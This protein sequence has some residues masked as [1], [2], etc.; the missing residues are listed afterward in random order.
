MLEARIWTK[1]LTLEEIVATANHSLTGYERELLAY[2]RMDEGKGETITDYAHGATLYL[3]GCS[4]NKQKGFSLRLDGTNRAQLDGNLLGRSTTY[5]ETILFW[6]KAESEGTLFCADSTVL[7]IE[8]GNVVF[9][10]GDQKFEITNHKCT[11]GAWH[12]LVLTIS[13]TY[14]NAALFLD[15]NLYLSFDALSLQAITGAMYLGGDGFT[16]NIDEFVIFEQALPKPLVEVYEDIALT[17]DEMGLMA[18]LPFEEQ[19][20]NPSGVLQLRFSGNDKRVYKNPETGEVIDKI[21]PLIISDVTGMEDGDNNAPVKSHG[22]LNKLNFNWSFNNNELMINILN[23]DYEVNKQSIYVSVRDVEDLNGNPMASPVT[24]T[25]FVDRNSLKWSSKQLIIKAD[26]TTDDKPEAE[27]RIVNQSGKRHT[28]NIE[29]LPSWLSVDE[30]YG[31]IDP[32][33]EIIVTL[34]CDRQIPVGEYSDLIY[35]TDENE[36]SEPLKVDFTIETI[37]PWEPANGSQFDQSM[38]LCGQVV[39]ADETEVLVFDTSNDDIVAA[40]CNG[41]LVGT[42]NNSFDNISNKSYVYL[43]IYGKADNENKPLSFKLWQASTGRVYNLTTEKVIQYHE[44]GIEGYTPAKPIVLTAYAGLSQQLTLKQGWNWISLN[45]KPLG[46]GDLNTVLPAAQGWHNEDLI[47]ST[48]ARSFAQFV[49]NDTANQ[50]IGTLDLIN[51]QNMYMVYVQEPNP[52]LMIDGIRLTNEERVITVEKGWNSIACLLDE[53]TPVSE[54]LA[55]Y[56]DMAT[57]GDLIKSKNAVA[58]FSPEGKWVGSLTHLRPGEGYLLYRYGE[59]ADSL[60]LRQAGQSNSEAVSQ[61]Q[62]SHSANGLTGGIIVPL[63]GKEADLF[64]NP[65]AATNMTMIAKLDNGQW[66]M[67]NGPL[68]VHVGSELAAVTAPIDSL[69]YLTIQSDQLGSLHFELNG[70]TL[71]PVGIPGSLDSEIPYSADA[72]YGSLKRPIVLKKNNSAVYKIIENNHVIIIRNNEKY[73]VTG[74]KL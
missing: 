4:W 74:K 24:W 65:N 68:K 18:Y 73:D 32:M 15:G 39:L 49:K 28:Y 13:R 31:A 56:Y 23:R 3:D 41:E 72:H 33:G 7:A 26:D 12:H 9:K 16:G 64:S 52:D 70:E 11:D 35:L 43:T 44:N 17:G 19:Y 55:D 66:T 25:A 2:Y 38:S 34:T 36:L 60:V 10:S 46:N 14:N 53:V 62:R 67:D 5:D 22:L 37:C 20:L 58:V 48:D 54:A 57:E 61:R 47:K 71:I 63:A 59:G 1:P 40:F 45:L 69:Y 21:V 50:W 42:A 29:S 30:P 27:V 51:Y 8:D 6:F